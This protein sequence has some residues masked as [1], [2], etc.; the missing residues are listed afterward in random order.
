MRTSNG[1][2]ITLRELNF[3][4]LGEERGGVSHLSWVQGASPITEGLK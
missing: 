1:G 3:R 2:L 4:S